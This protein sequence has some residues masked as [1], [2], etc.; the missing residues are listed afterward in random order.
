MATN[1]APPPYLIDLRE[2]VNLV[3]HLCLYLV[4]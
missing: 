2:C 1:Y 3:Y 4:Y